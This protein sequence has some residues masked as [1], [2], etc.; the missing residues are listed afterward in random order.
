MTLR[1]DS[2]DYVY[3]PTDDVNASTR[4]YVDELGAELV[5]KVRGMG[6]IV[7]CLRASETGPA[8]VTQ[9]QRADRTGA[10][11]GADQ[12]HRLRGK[13]LVEVAYRHAASLL[14]SGHRRCPTAANLRGS[15]DTKR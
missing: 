3:V 6:T 13:D 7:A 9:G 8:Q 1:F 2:L 4:R 5:W 15:D 10:R 12:R 11:R 14:G